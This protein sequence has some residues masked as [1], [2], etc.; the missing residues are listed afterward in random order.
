MHMRTRGQKIF[1]VVNFF[2]LTMIALSC[3]LP[4]MNI[5]ALSLSSTE[6]AAGGEVT[7]YPIGFNLIAYKNTMQRQAFWQSFLNSLI[8]VGI[9]VPLNMILTILAAFTLSRRE[10]KL[11]GRKIYVWFF[12][13]TMLFNGGLIPWY[14]TIRATGLLNSMWALILPSA[15]QV[16]NTILLVSFF[17]GVP[18][19][20][21]EAAIIDGSGPMGVLTNVYIPCSVPAIA[22]LTLFCLVNHW[23]E[24]FSGQ[25][26]MNKME[27]YPLMSYLQV[28]LHLS[29]NLEKLSE[30]E[31][32]ELLKVNLR[33]FN[34][35][36]LIIAMLPMLLAYP[37]FQRFFYN[38]I[39][40]GRR[41]RIRSS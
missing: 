38:R 7:L 28:L 2:L 25:I 26:L 10:D 37:F 21:E 16:Y 32:E 41:K 9:G 17:R 3:L 12:L 19:E 34:A 11:M 39:D 40:T 4:L 30:K 35:A 29:K 36:Q 33:T 22:T 31:I 18:Y 24:W 6:A 5:L 15:V 27:K 23:N 1:S 8:R 14:L 20:I 13:L